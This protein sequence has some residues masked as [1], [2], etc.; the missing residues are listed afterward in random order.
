MRKPWFLNAIFIFTSILGISNAATANLLD[1]ALD[2]A[3]ANV[4]TGVQP[5]TTTPAAQNVNPLRIPPSGATDPTPA[6]L[7]STA[8]LN[9]YVV[10]IQAGNTIND[11]RR[12][13]T[14]IGGIALNQ[15]D[16]T[17]SQAF[18]GFAGYFSAVQIQQ[19]KNS[20]LVR[21]IE[22]DAIQRSNATEPGSMQRQATWGLD[23]IDQT[24]LPLDNRYHYQYSGAGT[25]VYIVDTGIR[26]GHN[27]FG[28]RLGAGVNTTEPPGERPNGLLE[29]LF[30]GIFSAPP[31]EN[32][33]TDDCNGHGTHV[34]GTVGGERYGVAKATML[35]P[36]R[37]LNCEGAGSTSSVIAGLDWIADHAAAPAVVNM[38]LGGGVSR[39]MD[40]AVQN[41]SQRGLVVVVAAGNDSTN[42]CNHS[43]AR[44]KSAV[45][46]AASTKTDQRASFS[47][48]GRCVDLFAPGKDITAA[49]HTSDSATQTISG[50]SMAAP[51]VA[52][53]A[54]LFLE[55]RPEAPAAVIIDTILAASVSGKITDRQ[56][57][58]NQLLQSQ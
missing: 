34:A 5:E 48:Y 3:P 10:A 17:Y 2:D 25:H 20:A 43:P 27:E 1:D 41:L 55:T 45:T 4:P 49:W 39:A 50:T 44:E 51:H 19:L 8:P 35:H 16:Y 23:R 52:G 54:A 53:A 12:L 21:Y 7:P 22:R 46:V 26:H 9:R 30:D 58:P 40:E 32:R 56:G 31:D 15:V 37:V 28:Q 14:T 33:P 6:L 38:S 18:N 29:R 57:S 42:A 11:A 47:N 36:V 24:N 13:L